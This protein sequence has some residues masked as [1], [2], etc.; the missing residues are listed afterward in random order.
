MEE[1][2]D[3]LLA[4]YNGEMYLKEQLDSIL[5]QT[6]KN[7]N[8][9]IS[10]DCSTDSTREILK[11]YEKKDSRIKIYLQD[12]N[13]GY[14]RNF[15]FLLSKVESNYYALSDQD[16][17][18]LEDKI[19]KLYKK[20]IDTNSD[21]VHC[22]L[23]VVD[24]DLNTIYKSRWKKMNLLKKVKYDD[25]RSVYLYNCV[26][27]CTILSKRKFIKDI[28]PLP[29]KSKY[30]PHDYWISLVVAQKGKIAHTDE[31]LILYR[32]HGNN[33]IGTKR[34][35]TRM[36]KFEDVRNLFIQVKIEHFTDYIERE[37]IFN[38]EQNKLNREALEYFKKL[39][40]I[41]NIS[42][43]GLKTFHKL[44]KYED[45]SYYLLQCIILNFPAVSRFGFK[46]FKMIQHIFIKEG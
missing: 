34:T 44:Y 35:S 24:K 29:N 30:M 11:E 3:V 33:E 36:N 32:Q 39:K 20:M 46:I 43:K 45:I 21:L 17:V 2:I 15:E 19:E 6:Y 23:E 14:I 7:I 42:I 27:G 9:I 40:E 12:K 41:K 5:N 16:D 26:T 38:K 37:E 31:K 22:D 28:L 10:D 8:L 18:W 1:K 25:I 4:T 13:L